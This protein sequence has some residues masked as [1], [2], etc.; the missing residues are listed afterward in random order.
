L[1]IAAIWALP[2]VRFLIGEH[3]AHASYTHFSCITPVSLHRVL[4]K[5][6]ITRSP[7]GKNILNICHSCLGSASV[8][9][10]ASPSQNH[11][12]FDFCYPM[13]KSHRKQNR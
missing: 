12:H 2:I 1:L 10:I 3:A 9:S 6:F 5:V 8:V 4:R 11:L 7:E 13:M